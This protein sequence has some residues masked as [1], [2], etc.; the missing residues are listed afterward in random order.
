MLEFRSQGLRRDLRRHADVAGQRIGRHKLHFIDLDRALLASA[1]QRFFDLLGHVLGFG[2][3]H[4]K[5]AH[6][7][8]EVFDGHIFGEVQAGQTGRAQ[9]L[10]KAAFRLSGFQRNSIQQQLVVGNP[11]QKA[12][13]SG[14]GQ[15]LLQFVPG[16]LELRFRALVIRAV[17]ARVLDQNVQAVHEGPRRGRP[18][19][20]KCRC[21]ADKALLNPQL[22]L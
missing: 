16:G 12:A 1:A 15:S 7:P 11:Q 20:V 9:E 14:R 17:H 22:W 8:G 5:S 4:R 18:V 13:L 6:Q 3:S 10:P 21:V 19:C 2:A